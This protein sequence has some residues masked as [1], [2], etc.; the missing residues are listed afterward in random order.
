MSVHDLVSLL[1]LSLLT[2]SLPLLAQESAAG[3]AG[4]HARAVGTVKSI[5]G[6][7]VTL[8]TDS[9]SET[10][11]HASAGHATDAHPSRTN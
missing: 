6:S 2:V 4:P 9:G 3:R 10:D 7:N 5:D 8:T 11:H 1:V